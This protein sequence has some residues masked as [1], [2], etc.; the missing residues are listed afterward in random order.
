MFNLPVAAFETFRS[1]VRTLRTRAARHQAR[2]LSLGTVL[3]GLACLAPPA[4]LA[5]SGLR[6]GQVRVVYAE[7]KE[8]KHQAIRDAMQDRRILEQLQ[9][10]LNPIRLPRP[11]TLEVKGCDGTVD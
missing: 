7:P 6:T 11:L 8:V 9:T 2:L 10:L 1:A 4:L 5:E 3:A